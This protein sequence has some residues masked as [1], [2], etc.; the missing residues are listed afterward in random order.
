LD[1]SN[2]FINS[3]KPQCQSPSKYSRDEIDLE[4]TELNERNSY[5]DSMVDVL[6]TPASSI[7]SFSNS[8]ASNS[9]LFGRSEEPLNE[10]RAKNIETKPEKGNIENKSENKKAKKSRSTKNKNF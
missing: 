5:I 1:T 9:N 2:E 7:Q 8:K 3:L 10:E 4:F 6:E